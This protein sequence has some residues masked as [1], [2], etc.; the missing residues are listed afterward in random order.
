MSTGAGPRLTPLIGA[1]NPAAGVPCP[2]CRASGQ[3]GHCL[4]WPA[5]RAQRGQAQV[6]KAGQ[7]DVPGSRPVGIFPEPPVPIKLNVLVAETE[8]PPPISFGFPEAFVLPAMI[9]SVSVAVP[10]VLSKPSPPSAP[11]EFL[12]T[13]QLV[14]DSTPRLYKP[15]PP[16][17]SAVFPL[18]VQ[19]VSIAVP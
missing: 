13:V 15:A 12:L 4:G 19:F 6:C 3:Q 5:V 2:D 7:N 16:P 18:T 11:P 1:G 8:T 9:V 17:L 10:P 14:S